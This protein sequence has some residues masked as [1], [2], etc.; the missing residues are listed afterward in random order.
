KVLG[1]GG[2]EGWRG[3]EPF[4][5]DGRMYPAGSLVVP[6][7]QPFRAHAKDLLE[8]QHYTPVNDRPPYDVAG[9]TLPMTMNVRADVVNAPFTANL[10][11]VDSVVPTPGKIEGNGDVFVLRHRTNAE[12]R[13]IAQLLAAGQT[14][15]I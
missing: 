8:P 4:S 10:V 11:R 6:M 2:V 14:V 9:W 1:A 13:A 7:A 15:T 12:S 3:Q 5:I